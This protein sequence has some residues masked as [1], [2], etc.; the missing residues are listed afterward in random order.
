ML[1]RGAT[2]RGSRGSRNRETGNRVSSGAVKCESANVRNR[3]RWGGVTDDCWAWWC[4]YRVLPDNGRRWNMRFG[5]K[6]GDLPGLLAEWQKMGIVYRQ[7]GLKFSKYL[8]DLCKPIVKIGAMFTKFGPRFATFCTRFHHLVVNF[9][10]KCRHVTLNLGLKFRNVLVARWGITASRRG[11]QTMLPPWGVCSGGDQEQP[12]WHLNG[13]TF[14]TLEG[15][16]PMQ[17]TT[18]LR[19]CLHGWRC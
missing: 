1:N 8:A 17:S 15:V 19:M 16:K 13:A 7:R 2:L 12:C 6:N 18:Q 3:W 5:S 14:T 10:V 4:Q 11:T 9:R